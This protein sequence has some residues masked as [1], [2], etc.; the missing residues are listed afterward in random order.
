M[1]ARRRKAREQVE[2]LNAGRERLLAAYAAVRATLDDATAELTAVLGEARVAGDAA[3]RRAAAEPDPTVEELEAEVA[4]A[5]LVDPNLGTGEPEAV[6]PG[7]LAEFD[8]DPTRGPLSGEIPAFV[9]ETWSS[10]PGVSEPALV[11][12]EPPD[13][14]EGVR[15]LTEPSPGEPAPAEPGSGPQP[16]SGVDG[17]GAQPHGDTD[18]DPESL[19]AL[20]PV[21]SEVDD[22]FARLRAGQQPGHAPTSET[23]QG[24]DGDRAAIV[25]R[26]EAVAGIERDLTRV[27]K[28]LLADEQNEVLDLLRRTTPGAADE[29]LP[30]PAEHAGRWVDAARGP[31]ALAAAA[32]AR[33]VAPEVLVE[34]ARQDDGASASSPGVDGCGAQPHGSP[35]LGAVDPAEVPAELAEHMTAPLRDRIQRC[36]EQTDGDL[37]EVTERVRALYREWKGQRLTDAVRHHVLAAHAVGVSWALPAGCPVRWV[38]DSAAEPC[39]DAEDNALA[40]VLCHGDAFPTGHARPP[41]HPG[42]R[43]LIVRA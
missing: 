4:A 28:R 37:D 11:A 34:R 16:E 8:H 22:L 26:D 2:K 40:G 41:A 29:V 30:P 14:V 32:G 17:G 15:V 7:D 31:L 39:P 43:C 3:A 36:F 19:P 35:V 6:L 18:P 12:V 27:L 25:V 9:A 38:L 33:S 21:A 10:E 24:Q 23:T 42:C 1:A 13:E 5:R 20:A